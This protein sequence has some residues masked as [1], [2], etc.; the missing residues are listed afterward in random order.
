[1]FDVT[2]SS[3]CRQFKA[4]IAKDAARRPTMHVDALM[5][6]RRNIQ[7]V[8]PRIITA[9]FDV[10]SLPWPAIILLADG[11]LI[12]LPE[13]EGESD[14]SDLAVFVFLSGLE[15][16]EKLPRCDVFQRLDSATWPADFDFADQGVLIESKVELQVACRRIADAV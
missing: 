11:A 2:A 15:Q 7:K 5:L 6:L 12:C 1:M 8:G 3:C 16:L 9:L 4:G 14:D 10:S 13:C